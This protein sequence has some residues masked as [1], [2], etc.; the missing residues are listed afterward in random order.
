[1]MHEEQNR[2]TI[3]S[4]WQAFNQRD[5]IAAREQLTDD[6]ICEWPQ[7]NERIRGRD[8][9][10]AVNQNFPGDWQ[11]TVER[12]IVSGDQAASEVS[13]QLTRAEETRTDVAVSF[14]ELRE[15]KI[16]KEVDYWPNPYPAPA[17]RAQWVE[18]IK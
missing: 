10:I 18:P 12:V 2:Q 11:I 13:I 6:F 17:G 15:G 7:S 8:N 1:M 16:N 4:L 3:V 9:F 5:W 14:Y